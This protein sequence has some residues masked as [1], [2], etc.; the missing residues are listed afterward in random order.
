MVA[1]LAMEELMCEYVDL[2]NWMMEWCDCFLS[3]VIE[4][5]DYYCCCCGTDMRI[6]LLVLLLQEMR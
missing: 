6:V 2:H 4:W 1:C 5:V 3:V